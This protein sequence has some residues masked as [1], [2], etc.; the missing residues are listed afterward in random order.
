MEQIPHKQMIIKKNHGKHNQLLREVLQHLLIMHRSLFLHPNIHS[1]KQVLSLQIASK[2]SG[3]LQITNDG[4]DKTIKD[5]LFLFHSAVHLLNSTLTLLASEE[6]A[7][8]HIH[9]HSLPFYFVHR[10]LLHSHSN[11]HLL[12]HTLHRLHLLRLCTI[13]CSANSRLRLLLL[14]QELR[15][16]LHSATCR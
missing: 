4:K 7:T 16:Q 5:S 3:N 1:L 6:Q 12:L 14:R 15:I 13:R 11:R 9:T 10:S 2:N 8:L